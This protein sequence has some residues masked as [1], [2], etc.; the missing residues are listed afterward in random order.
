MLNERMGC[1]HKLWNDWVPSCVAQETVVCVRMC[2]A[3]NKQQGE[4]G[5]NKGKKEKVH[6]DIPIHVPDLVFPS[7]RVAALDRHRVSFGRRE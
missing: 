6:V 3:G 7:R 5:E 4:A 2:N 1:S